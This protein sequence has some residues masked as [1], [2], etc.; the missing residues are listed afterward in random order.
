MTRVRLKSVHRERDFLLTAELAHEIWREHYVG[1]I[2]SEQIEY[3]LEHF[4]SIS[5]IKTAQAQGCEYYIIRAGCANVGYLAI[6]PC[7]PRGKM[8]LSKFYILKEY[9]G[10]G[11]AH[12]ALAEIRENAR[13]LHLEHIWLTVAKNNTPSIAAYERMGFVN[14]EDICTDIGGG[15]V[16]N[17]HIFELKV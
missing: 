13:A 12:G 15:F 3:M 9:R 7:H 10:H 17:D 4:Q 11:Y 5:A 14:T 2:S 1:I 6:E 8:F 16:M